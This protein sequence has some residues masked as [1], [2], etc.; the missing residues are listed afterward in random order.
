MVF[1]GRG[2]RVINRGH[3]QIIQIN[4]GEHG[5]KTEVG[6]QRIKLRDG[7]MIRMNGW[8]T[9]RQKSDVGCQMSGKDRGQ[10]AED[11]IIGRLGG[12]MTGH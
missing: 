9:E 2:R 10:K 11:G 12:W 7:W 3:C 8:K 5:G 1:L 6:G 4:H